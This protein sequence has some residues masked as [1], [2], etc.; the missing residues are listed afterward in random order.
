MVRWLI[1]LSTR[2]HFIVAIIAAVVL[3]VGITQL[4]TMPVDVFPEFNPHLSKYRQRRW[5]YQ[6]PR[7]SH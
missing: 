1:Q 3:A 7:S 4:R 5:V 6:R 2:L